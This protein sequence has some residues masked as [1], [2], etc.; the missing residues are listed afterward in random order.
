MMTKIVRS[1]ADQNTFF[2]IAAPQAKRHTNTT[3]PT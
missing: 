3:E 2:A 1:F